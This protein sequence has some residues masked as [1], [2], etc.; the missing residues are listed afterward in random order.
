MGGTTRHFQPPRPSSLALWRFDAQRDTKQAFGTPI[1][2]PARWLRPL[3][4]YSR[5]GSVFLRHICLSSR[6]N[7]G[8]GSPHNA[9]GSFDLC[10]RIFAAVLGQ[11][12]ELESSLRASPRPHP[13]L[14]M[15]VVAHC[16]MD[17]RR[18]V[19]GPLSA[20]S[21]RY[22]QIGD[23]DFGAVKPQTSLKMAT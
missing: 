4:F 10:R 9:R 20:A 17:A 23:S 3:G 18:P 14:K 5:L 22:L 12:G 6:Q 16:M 1:S 15:R 8:T 13:V 21:A 19:T 2:P 11:E 7:L